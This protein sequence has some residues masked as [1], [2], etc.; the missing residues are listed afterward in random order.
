MLRGVFILAGLGWVVAEVI[1]YALRT[2]VRRMDATNGA[3]VFLTGVVGQG[4]HPHPTAF[5][6]D[7]ARFGL[8]LSPGVDGWRP[9]VLHGLLVAIIVAGGWLLAAALQAVADTV[10]AQ[11]R[12]RRAGQPGGHAGRTPK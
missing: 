11:V 12:L 8:V 7:G 5:A 10:K 4:P 1:Q 9:A 6:A 2:T 3:G